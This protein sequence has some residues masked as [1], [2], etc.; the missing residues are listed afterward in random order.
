MC[1]GGAG[2][3]ALGEGGVVRVTVC[4]RGQGRGVSRGET[5]SVE[6]NLFELELV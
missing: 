3:M 2:V 1:L 5:F 4:G 6:K